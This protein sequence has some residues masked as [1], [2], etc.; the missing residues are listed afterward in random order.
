VPK[1]LAARWEKIPGNVEA[2]KLKIYKTAT[3]AR[4]KVTL[5]LS[6]ATLCLKEEGENDI[7]KEHDLIAGPV[8]NQTLAAFDVELGEYFK[9]IKDAEELF[10][11][12]VGTP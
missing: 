7:P 3:G 2:G 10:A 9:R 5:S 6:E 8:V 4:P 11:N 12:P 1:Y